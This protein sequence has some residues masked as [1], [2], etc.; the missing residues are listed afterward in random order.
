MGDFKGMLRVVDYVVRYYGVF[1]VWMGFIDVFLMMVYFVIVCLV[2][3]GL[4]LDVI[5]FID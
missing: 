2:F 3:L 5:I 1:F 4:G